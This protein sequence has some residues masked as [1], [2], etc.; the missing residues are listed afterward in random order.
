MIKFYVLRDEN[1]NVHSWSDVKDVVI[2]E[3][4]FAGNKYILSEEW[5]DDYSWNWK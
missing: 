2:S 1:N 3:N 5:H 4:Y